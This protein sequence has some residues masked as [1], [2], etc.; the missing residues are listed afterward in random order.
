MNRS[1]LTV[2]IVGIV[3]LLVGMIGGP[4]LGEDS[5]FPIWIFTFLGIALAIVGII[6]L[7]VRRTR[8]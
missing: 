6:L 1:G 5:A 3:C 4:A 7:V 2:L 8:A